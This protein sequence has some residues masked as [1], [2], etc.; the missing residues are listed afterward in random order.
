MKTIALGLALP[1]AKTS[2]SSFRSENKRRIVANILPYG[3][4]SFA[5]NPYVRAPTCRLALRSTYLCSTAKHHENTVEVGKSHWAIELTQQLLLHLWLSIPRMHL[6]MLYML[7][8][9]LTPVSQCSSLMRSMY[10]RSPP[11]QRPLMPPFSL[12]AVLAS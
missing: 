9:F 1:S 11:Q 6:T 2:A 7:T 3:V 10:C 12:F 5:V 8:F 4:L